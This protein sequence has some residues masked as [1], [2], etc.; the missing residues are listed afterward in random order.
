[1]SLQVPEEGIE[2]SPWANGAG[3]STT[4]KA[5]HREV[6]KRLLCPASGAVSS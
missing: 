2:R 3:K 6:W 5:K 4:L 1:V